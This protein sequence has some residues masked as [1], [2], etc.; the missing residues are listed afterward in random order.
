MRG[1]KDVEGRGP[2]V[3]EVDKSW[4]GFKWLSVNEK[5]L[6]SIAFLRSARPESESCLVCACNFIPNEH[7]GF[8]IGLPHAG[9]LREL[10]S[11]DG[12]EFGGNGLHNAGAIVSR[13][14]EYE[15]LPYSAQID[16]P[17]LST[18]YFEYIP[19]RTDDEHEEGIQENTQ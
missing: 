11:S 10:L 6:S 16:L 8:T 1:P 19:E 18:V 3:Y 15:G 7:R 2:G 14:K 13:D 17:P 5:S 12:A 9:V 4:D